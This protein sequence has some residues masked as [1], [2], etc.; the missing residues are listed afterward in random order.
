[1]AVSLGVNRSFFEDPGRSPEA[2]DLRAE[3]L[4]WKLGKPGFPHR[5]SWA[6]DVSELG[7]FVRLFKNLRS[8]RTRRRRPRPERRRLS[9]GRPPGCQPAL[10]RTFSRSPE[11][12]VLRAETRLG[13][14]ES[15]LSGS[16]RPGGRPL[17]AGT[18]SSGLSRTCAPSDP[19]V[20]APFRAEAAIYLPPGPASTACRKESHKPSSCRTCRTPPSHVQGN[21]IARACAQGACDC[22]PGPDP[23]P[24]VRLQIMPL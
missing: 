12:P 14:Q 22:A 23:T 6:A 3:P 2:L 20:A 5:R 8:R 10:F 16:L 21:G 11:A 24:P 4:P 9:S 15:E 1:M 19:F 13:R 17:G 18:A 7:D